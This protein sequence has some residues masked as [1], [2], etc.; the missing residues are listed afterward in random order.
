MSRLVFV[1]G[2]LKHG[3]HNN[4]LLHTATL[5]KADTVEGFK[6]YDC[7]FPIAKA[8]EGEKI[9]GEL[10]EIE[11]DGT[12]AR[13]DRLESNGSM[14]NRTPVVTSSGHECEMYVGGESW[15]TGRNRYLDECPVIDGAYTWS[16]R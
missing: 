13:L 12:L 7:G 10:Y 6:L 4:S 1:Y 5:V 14:Y 16:S 11:D 15:W 3:Y 8:S 9:S 2:T